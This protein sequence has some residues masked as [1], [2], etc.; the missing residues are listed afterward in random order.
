MALVGGRRMVHLCRIRR[1]MYWAAVE[2]KVEGWQSVLWGLA[3]EVEKLREN[4]ADDA[5]VDGS[6]CIRDQ[7]AR[8]QADSE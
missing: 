6:E 8:G 5:G 3:L 2:V 7:N 1:G 4:D